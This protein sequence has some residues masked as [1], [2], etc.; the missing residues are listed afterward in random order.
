[1]GTK[2]TPKKGRPVGSGTIPADQRKTRLNFTLPP[3]LA[4]AFR[5]YC[6]ARDLKMSAVVA[7][8]IERRMTE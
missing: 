5:S 2:Q 3:S 4:D 8:M 6:D 1:M 7:E